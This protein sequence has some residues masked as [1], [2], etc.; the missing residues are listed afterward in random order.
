MRVDVPEDLL[1]FFIGLWRFREAGRPR[2]WC[3][4]YCWRGDYYDVQGQN[5]PEEAFIGMRNGL[6]ELRRKRCSRR[7]SSSSSPRRA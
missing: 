4:T 5:T 6:A 2:Q 1:A 3:I 7:R